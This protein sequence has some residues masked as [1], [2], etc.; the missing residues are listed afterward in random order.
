MNQ[1]SKRKNKHG[2]NIY[3]LDK[4]CFSGEEDIENLMPRMTHVSEDTLLL[5]I[6]GRMLDQFKQE[7]QEDSSSS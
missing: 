4:E 7:K 3:Q 5:N 2:R 6:F 1:E